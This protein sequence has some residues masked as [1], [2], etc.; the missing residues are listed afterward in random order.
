MDPTLLILS[1]SHGR[2]DRIAEV[3][4]RV[5]PA[6]L[7]FAGDGVRDLSRVSIDCPLWAVRGN[8][9]WMSDPIVVGDGLLDPPEEELFFWEGLRILLCHGHRYGVKSGPS[10]A[11]AQAVLRG[12]DILIFGHTHIPI[13][14]RVPAGELF[15]GITPE[16][17][18]LVFNPGSLGESRG[19]TFGTL[20]VRGGVPLLA[21]G[22]F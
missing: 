6:G 4:R 1:D 5:K 11:I 3:L 7:V 21:H 10:V 16:K 12:A 13:E 8:C 17:P 14:Y 2:P 19:A 9:D 18:L 22:E 20:T 15:G